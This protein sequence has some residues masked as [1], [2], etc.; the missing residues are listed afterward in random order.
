MHF[1][2]V[3]IYTRTP[4]CSRCNGVPGNSNKFQNSVGH[5]VAFLHSLPYV[6][7]NIFSVL[8]SYWSDYI[9]GFS[10]WLADS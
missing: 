2:Y 3:A 4:S 7:N 1:S 10:D 5:E 9:H 6:K 8:V